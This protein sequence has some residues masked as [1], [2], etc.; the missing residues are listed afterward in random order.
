MMANTQEGASLSLSLHRDDKL[1]NMLVLRLVDAFQIK[2]ELFV[3]QMKN[4][5]DI[6][7]G[8]THESETRNKKERP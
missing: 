2:Q 6:R 4:L 5:R 8:L 3:E 7:L 1:T